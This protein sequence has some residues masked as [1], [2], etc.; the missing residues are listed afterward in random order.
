MKKKLL[1]IILA[2][3]MALSVC[4]CGNDAT[5][6]NGT[7]E[8][9]VQEATET[10]SS[11][12]TETEETK[13]KY[14]LVEEPITVK[15]LVA[16]T[17]N[18]GEDRLIHQKV[19]ELTGINI[20][21]EVVDP[22]ALATILASGDWPDL[23]FINPS[24]NQILDYG[25]IGEKFVD[26]LKY[27]D[28]MPNLAQTME[29]YPAM[30]LAIQENGAM[31]R[32]PFVS[33]IATTC[34]AR[35]YINT[36]VLEKAG[37]ER[38][39]TVDEFEQAL[40][41]LQ[42]YYGE[43][44][45]FIPKLNV[46]TGSWAQMLFAAFGE[47]TDMLLD[48][49]KSGEV[50]FSHTTD[51]MKHYYEFMHKLYDQGLIHKEVATLDAATKKALEL[52]GKI[53]FLDTAATSIAANE[54]GEFPVSLLAPLTSQ[55]DST[56]VV[57]GA[58]GVSFTHSIFMNSESEYIEELCQMLD[59]AYATEE[60]AEGTGLH[61]QSFMHGIEGENFKLNDDGLTYTFIV[62]EGYESGNAYQTKAIQWYNFGRADYLGLR[63]EDKPSNSQARQKGIVEYMKP[64]MENPKDV[65][66]G[67]G[68]IPFNEEQ[69]SIIDTYWEAMVTYW[70]KMQ[71]EFITGVADIETG[72]DEYVATLEKMG[73][74]E[75]MK[76][77]NEAWD[78]YQAK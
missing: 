26:Y 18:G 76:A 41:D 73:L 47:H 50:I 1:S 35:P 27:I 68:N 60:V 67:W 74:N 71:V 44:S 4:A 14:P 9:Q 36:D 61:G 57:Q 75:V 12:A 21:W 65:F 69:Q 10:Q 54:K 56:Q 30:K 37:V 31:Y 24:A 11:A 20:E 72:W 33:M 49:D 64:Y 52:E 62:P 17:N 15:G 7:S 53:A 70:Q 32:L 66:P 28:L 34:P 58:M 59:I 6:A 43:E 29:D 25:V 22:E 38:P 63:I 16:I 23:L 39:A 48:L 2:S 78:D 55:Y 46:Y 3:A 45:V 51:Q 13:S 8:S 77:I 19:A 40:K 42:A 5:N